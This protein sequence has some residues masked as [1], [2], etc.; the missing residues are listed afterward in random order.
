MSNV[1][2]T[3]GPSAVGPLPLFFEPFSAISHLAG[4]FLFL[5]LGL[6]LLRRGRGSRLR[7]AFLGVYVVSGVFL[8]AMSGVYHMLAPGLARE[9]MRRLDH[10]AIFIL[11]AGSYTPAHG[12]LFSGWLRWGP[13]ALVWAAAI[14]GITLKSIFFTS[15]S[16]W[17]G[18][19]FYLALGWLGVVSAV[20]IVRRYGCGLLKPLAAGGIA[21]SIGGLVDLHGWLVLIPGIIHP[22]EVF[23]L[24]VLTG[25]FC[26]WLFV[27]CFATGEVI[28]PQ[29][30]RKAVH[31][32]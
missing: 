7:L 16:H 4:A 8:F 32:L 26:H 23:H 9:V 11:I 22:H 28:L 1:A 3:A 5:A 30:H 12:I 15:L 6:L 27:W 25:A 21:Y 31:S 17:I 29:S 20:F 24:A 2:A 14:T 10:S 13:L 19:S 18:L